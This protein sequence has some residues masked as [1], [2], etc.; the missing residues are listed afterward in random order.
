[1]QCVVGI[2]PA[3]LKRDLPPPQTRIIGNRCLRPSDLGWR[4]LLLILQ[5]QILRNRH[6]FRHERRVGALLHIT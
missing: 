4:I 6:P 2:S 3:V 5:E 1:M